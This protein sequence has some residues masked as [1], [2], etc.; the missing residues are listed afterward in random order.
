M[1]ASTGTSRQSIRFFVEDD[2][3]GDFADRTYE[4]VDYITSTKKRTAFPFTEIRVAN[5]GTAD[6]FVSFDGINIHDVVRPGETRPYQNR[7]E[8]MVAVR[9]ETGPPPKT[10]RFRIDAW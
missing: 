8:S 9:S 4:F 2:T 10:A 1:P 6:V 7:V 5:D 3:T